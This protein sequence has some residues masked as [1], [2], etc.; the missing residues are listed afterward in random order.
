MLY[1]SARWGLCVEHNIPLLLS[2]CQTLM[3]CNETCY[4]VFTPLNEILTK[5]S[6]SISL[7]KSS[8][9]QLDSKNVK[10]KKP[11]PPRI[12]SLEKKLCSSH[13]NFWHHTMFNCMSRVLMARNNKWLFKA[14]YK[15]Q[16]NILS[17]W[18]RKHNTDWTDF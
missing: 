14:E 11:K 8:S 2:K 10:P 4:S 6:V 3:L 16:S 1:L 18:L 5:S 13:I 12:F 15:K 7:E 17:F 9:Y